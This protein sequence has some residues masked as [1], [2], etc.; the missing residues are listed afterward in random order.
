MMVGRSNFPKTREQL[1]RDIVDRLNFVR[2]A[3]HV[4]GECRVY[5]S[6]VSGF[7][8]SGSKKINKKNS[9]LDVRANFPFVAFQL[10]SVRSS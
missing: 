2:N 1:I 5:G 10:R 8:L 4:P 6:F 3:V 9:S 7:A